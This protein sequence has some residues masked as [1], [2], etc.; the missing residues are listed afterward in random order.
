MP[1]NTLELFPQGGQMDPDGIAEWIGVPVPDVFDQL[2]LGN[3]PP[4]IQKKILQNGKLLCRQPDGR[5]IKRGGS[6]QRVQGELSVGQA[7]GLLDKPAVQQ[8]TD[9]GFQLG[10]EEGLCQ[11]IAGPQF[12]PGQLAV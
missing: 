3:Q 10:K 11:I 8:D 7:A 9:A 1:Q 6:V 5:S 12:K 4:W 2:L